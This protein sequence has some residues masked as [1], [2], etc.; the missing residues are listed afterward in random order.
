MEYD[1]DRKQA[2]EDEPK[3]IENNLQRLRQHAIV[4]KRFENMK[5][6]M[7][8]KGLGVL[9]A[10]LDLMGQQLSYSKTFAGKFGT[11]FQ[12]H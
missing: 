4:P 2:F 7:E 6:D 5:E 11:F 10:L 8:I 1:A 3:D 12:C 9:S